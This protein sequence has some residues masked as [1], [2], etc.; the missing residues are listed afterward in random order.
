MCFT[1]RL[2]DSLEY[3]PF[4]AMQWQMEFTS[5]TKTRVGID[6]FMGKQGNIDDF[7]LD[8]FPD[9]VLRKL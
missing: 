1:L 3:L 2:N 6:N 8:L 5:C 4:I 7:Q 9:Y